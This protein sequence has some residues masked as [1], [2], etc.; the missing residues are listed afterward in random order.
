M[1]DDLLFSWLVVETQGIIDKWDNAVNGSNKKNPP[2][3]KWTGDFS[4]LADAEIVT[5]H[6]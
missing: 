3:I 4:D 5:S 2:S 6:A 1:N